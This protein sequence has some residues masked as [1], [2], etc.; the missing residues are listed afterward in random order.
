MNKSNTEN[1]PS[2][3]ESENNKD[4]IF[5]LEFRNSSLIV[6]TVLLIHY[7]N[8]YSWHFSP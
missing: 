7:V 4:D 1:I 2:Q 8:C 3:F 6:K 5:K